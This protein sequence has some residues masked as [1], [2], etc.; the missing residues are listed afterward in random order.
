MRLPVCRELG[1]Y[2]HQ[3]LGVLRSVR[4]PLFQEQVDTAV[5][6]PVRILMPPNGT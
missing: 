6:F 3:E 1:K 4:L 5:A 2:D